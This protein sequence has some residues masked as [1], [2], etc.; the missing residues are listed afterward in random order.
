MSSAK[1][2]KNTGITIINNSIGGTGSTGQAGNAGI[3]SEYAYINSA[4]PAGPVIVST[5]TPILFT[6][7]NISSG[8]SYSALSGSLT[9]N[10]PGIYHV[11]FGYNIGFPFGSNVGLYL[12]GIA[13]GNQYIISTNYNATNQNVWNNSLSVI[14]N[15]VTPFSVLQVINMSGL[16]LYLGTQAANDSIIAYLTVLSHSGDQG[17]TG[18]T[19]S[20]GLIGPT[21]VIGPTGAT[22]NNG[23]SG[24]LGSTGA[25]GST[26]I[27]GPIGLIGATGATGPNTSST[28]AYLRMVDLVAFPVTIL[29]NAPIPYQNSTVSNIT[30]TPYSGIIGITT[31]G[32]YKL[33][34]GIRSG[35]P[36]GAHVSVYINGV[37]QYPDHSLAYKYNGTNDNEWMGHLSTIINIPSNL[38]TLEI[39]N[40]ALGG[41]DLLLG[42]AESTNRQPYAYLTIVRIL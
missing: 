27:I 13:L 17:M 2:I 8:F 34:F 9:F 35:S 36:F 38:S 25:T 21:G 24:L 22:G 15:I 10:K 29:S 20:I 31:G 19:G 33:D 4:G 26:G 42:P 11:T 23:T 18:A 1:N 28:F 3:D 14:L 39:R 32:T 6:N 30:Y 41:V 40:T 12:N 16:N 37:S 5:F 7:A